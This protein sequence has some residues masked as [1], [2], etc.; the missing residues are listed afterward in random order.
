MQNGAEM[1]RISQQ[2]H[3]CHQIGGKIIK[4]C[5]VVQFYDLALRLG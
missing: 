5:E 2:F 3:L 4:K 1:S